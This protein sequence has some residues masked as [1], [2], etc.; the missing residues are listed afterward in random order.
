MQLPM[1]VDRK[2]VLR[3]FEVRIWKCGRR[4][5]S[6]K[7][8]VLG[9]ADARQHPHS[10]SFINAFKLRE[11]DSI[12]ICRDSNGQLMVECDTPTYPCPAVRSKALDQCWGRKSA[13]AAVAAA[14]AAASAAL[15][16]SVQ[17]TP[18]AMP[19]GTPGLEITTAAAVTASRSPPHANSSVA[20][21]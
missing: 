15:A 2:G 19:G 21:S 7:E 16:A 11:G 9:E 13:K 20:K 4:S 17:K 10:D 5:R 18:E 1:L 6:G 8:Y 14:A 12:G 3:T